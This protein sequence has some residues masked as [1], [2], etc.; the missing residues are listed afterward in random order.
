M[1]RIQ[2]LSLLALIAICVF[3]PGDKIFRLKVPAFIACWFVFCLYN[4]SA[5]RLPRLPTKLLGW[6]SFFLILPVLS[7][8]YYHLI[9]GRTPY[10]GFQYLKSYLF[11]T[12]IVVIYISNLDLTKTFYG[13]LSMLSVLIIGIFVVT[14][15]YPPAI[16][17]LYEFGFDYECM[18]L[19]QRNYG[20]MTF[21]SIFY[22]TTPMIVMAITYYIFMSI[23]QSA[24]KNKIYVVLSALNI[25]AMYLAGTRNNILMAVIAPLLI[26]FMYSKSKVTIRLL[27]LFA[28]A[29]IFI[30]FF[31]VFSE[32]FSAT[33]KSNEFK[34]GYLEDYR[35]VFM[36]PLTFFFGQGLGAY[37]YWS[38]HGSET[39]ITELTFFEIFR[40]YGLI[41]GMALIGLILFPLRAIN[42]NVRSAKQVMLI[43]YGC[44]L[45][46]CFSNPLFFSSTGILVLSIVMSS[47]F[48]TDTIKTPKTELD[49]DSVANRV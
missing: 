28:S 24:G 27:V 16:E 47:L 6:L 9:D 30:Y 22:K 39:A 20:S 33:E 42:I 32:M 15:I 23:T 37:S 45:V 40:N 38:I 19:G 14:S 41:G 7:I 26:L 10:D 4:L 21:V 2:Y 34:F 17:W 1:K 29:A 46:M 11:A 8:L 44:Y 49:A 36:D 31:D 3:D 13:V 43:G 48:M 12:I 5:S 25:F 35:R 18:Q